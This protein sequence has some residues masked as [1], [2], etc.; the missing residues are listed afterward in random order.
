MVQRG[1]GGY[2]HGGKAID[3]YKGHDLMFDTLCT[4]LKRHKRLSIF[5]VLFFL[6]SCL[7]LAFFYTYTNH[8]APEIENQPK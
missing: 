6:L 1:S 5:M 3:H 4:S 7:F 8:A 2:L